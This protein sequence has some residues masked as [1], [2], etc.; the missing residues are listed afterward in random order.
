MRAKQPWTVRIPLI[1]GLDKSKVPVTIDDLDYHVWLPCSDRSAGF[2]IDL[3]EGRYTHYN[4]DGFRY[5]YL[6]NNQVHLLRNFFKHK[7]LYSF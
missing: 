6:Y 4:P 3:D 1:A 5:I 7:Y 2:V